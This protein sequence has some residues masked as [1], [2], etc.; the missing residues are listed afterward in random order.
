MSRSG[1]R[2]VRRSL[3]PIG[4]EI[5]EALTPHD[6]GLGI[7]ELS[8]VVG[9]EVAQAHRIVR[10]LVATGWVVQDPTT[11]AY[12][13]TGALLALAGGQLQRLDLRLAAAPTLR[14]VREVT[15][16]TVVLA[17][18]RAGQL[19]CVARELSEAAIL[20]WAQIGES[21]QLGSQA[22]VSQ[23]VEAAVL[24][25]GQ[26]QL[27]PSTYQPTPGRVAELE[28]GSLRGWSFDDSRYRPGGCAVASAVFDLQSRPV[29]AVGIAWP[30]DRI[31]HERVPELGDLV[32]TSAEEVS[33]RLGY[34]RDNENRAWRS[35][36]VEREEDLL[37]HLRDLRGLTYEGA[38]GR[39]AQKRTFERA[40]ALLSPVIEEVVSHFSDRMLL[41]SGLI[42]RDHAES[43]EDGVAV[44][45]SLS[46]PA[47]RAAIAQATGRPLS[48][49]SVVA[50]LRPAHIHGH[51][52]GSYFGD[53]PMQIVTSSDARRQAPI[54][55]AI[56][57]AEC[58]QRIFEAGGD[59]RLIPAYR[60]QVAEATTTKRR[61]GV[62]RS[63]ALQVRDVPV[64]ITAP[65][66]AD[67]A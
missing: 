9:L 49:V 25:T 31:S 58:H 53:W 43:D 50:R 48:P 8:K 20:T 16:E 38:V 34:R 63:S 45:W 41:G 12:Q 51:L 26:T 62:A 64:R 65:L 28:E 19:Y 56:V 30:C 18:L 54:L 33:A 7:T 47:Q 36:A 24:A 57:E 3:A 21:W 66:E 59:W 13:V 39:E 15:G 60:S 1:T 44:T 55:L 32:R 17:E 4:L 6:D 35:I 61:S 29:G 37:R 5:L 10:E 40:V 14:R 67:G 11:N 27:F 42:E 2:A 52:G 23:A 22:A 46:W